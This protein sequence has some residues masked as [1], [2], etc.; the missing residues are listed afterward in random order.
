VGAYFADL[1][2]KF[3]NDRYNAK[4]MGL[5]HLTAA[6][7]SSKSLDVLIELGADWFNYLE[8]G[9]ILSIS[10]TTTRKT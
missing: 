5:L 6:C 2:Q 1:N 9:D 7:G 8:M 4:E 3:D 10:V